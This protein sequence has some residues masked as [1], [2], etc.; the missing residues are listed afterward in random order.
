MLEVGFS[1]MDVRF[2]PEQAELRRTARR[3]A[4][5]LGPRSVAGLAD[6]SRTLRLTEAVHDAGWIELRRSGGDGR[7]LASGVEASILAEAL[8][9][10]A[11]DVPFIGPTLAEDLARR[12]GVIPTAG[13][14]IAFAPELLGPLMVSGNTTQGA[15]VVVDDGSQGPVTAYL[16][17]TAGDGHRLATA[18]GAAAAV[19]EGRRDGADLTRAIGLLPA[20]APVHFVPGAEHLTH[21]DLCS[22]TALG[23][24]LTNADLVGSMRGV[25]EV[26][27][28]YARERRQFGVA[29]GSFQAVQHL[30]AEAH[31]LIE[32]AFSASLYSAWAVD[33]LSPV[34]AL[35]ASRVAKA[36]C[37]RAARTVCE[38]AVQVHGGIGN[39]WDCI[40]HVY[41]R[42][43][44]LSSRWFGDDGEQIRQLQRTR[45]MVPDGLS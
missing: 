42:R 22:W 17:A 23:L 18:A 11:A 20:G 33:E 41:L 44:L 29:V 8:G 28:A 9:E 32:G 21:D 19:A 5:E 39:T 24:A 40:V 2:T 27:V 14:A 6:R 34:E 25:L 31:C 26:T 43:A 36:Y 15:S 1:L 37:A 3:L 16:L 7:P 45:L 38:T 35:A 10:A 12:A 30:V 4:R 13:H